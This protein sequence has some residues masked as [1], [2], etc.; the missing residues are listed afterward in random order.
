MR[1]QRDFGWNNQ[2]QQA[3]FYPQNQLPPNQ[4]P[5][6]NQLPPNQ[7]P[8]QQQP[9]QYQSRIRPQNSPY[10]EPRYQQKNSEFVDDNYDASGYGKEDK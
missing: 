3:P 1:D 4:L 7:L 8:Y 6:Q 9:T 2:N 5:Y 10:L